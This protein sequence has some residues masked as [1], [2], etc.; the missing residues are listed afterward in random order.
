MSDKPLADLNL[1]AE[2]KVLLQES[3]FV[4]ALPFVETVVLSRPRTAAATM[5][6]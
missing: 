4:Q 6:R 1:K 5:R 2:T 3:L